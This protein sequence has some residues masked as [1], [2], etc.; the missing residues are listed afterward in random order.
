M[1]VAIAGAGN[2][3]PLHRLGTSARPATRSSS[4]RRTSDLVRK[5]RDTMDV[6][7]HPA[8]ACEVPSLQRAGLDQST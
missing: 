6:E 4:S 3:G 7:W 2:V 1:R 8:D 5:L